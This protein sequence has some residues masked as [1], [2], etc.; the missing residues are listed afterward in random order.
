VCQWLDRWILGEADE[1]FVR[2]VRLRK[3]A[4]LGPR[5]S[6]DAA[7]QYVGIGC[8]VWMS[9]QRGPRIILLL[10]SDVGRCQD[11]PAM[12]H[13]RPSRIYEDAAE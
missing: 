9:P 1:C 13:A 7:V 6:K 5:S 2:S 11:N 3:R 4:P 12:R 8:W 10:C